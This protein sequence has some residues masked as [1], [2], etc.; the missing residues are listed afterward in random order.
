MAVQGQVRHRHV[1][2]RGIGHRYHA[3][4]RNIIRGSRRDGGRSGFH[5]RD[6]A[7][8]IDG[9]YRVIGRTPYNRLI[10]GVVRG[11]GRHQRVAVARGQADFVA[12]QG[13]AR[14]RYVRRR[15]IGNG[16]L[17]AG[18]LHGR[19]IVHVVLIVIYFHRRSD[20]SSLRAVFDGKGG[21]KEMADGSALR[22][23]KVEKDR[24]F[25]RGAIYLCKIA[26]SQQVGIYRGFYTRKL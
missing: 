23:N 10:G 12:I 9:H 8:S 18:Y 15:R 24:V 16:D 4:I 14:H 26:I 11:D 25:F 17:P 5:R 13:Q 1:R 6:I 21:G 20:G 3:G 2:G 22:G 19:R 7:V